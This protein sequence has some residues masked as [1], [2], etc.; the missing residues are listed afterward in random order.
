MLALLFSFILIVISGILLLYTLLYLI[1]GRLLFLSRPIKTTIQQWIAQ[2]YPES[3]L[4]I[5]TPDKTQLHGWLLKKPSIEKSPLV[6]YFGGNSEE[7]SGNAYHFERFDGDWA[8][9]L[10]NY[11]SYGLSKGKPSEKNL[12]ND[13]IAIY[14][15]IIQRSDIDSHCIVAMG[16]S[17]GTGI[18]IHLAAHRPLNGL[19]LVTPYDSIT[20]VIQR[21]MPYIPVYQLLKHP[22]N[23]LAL[24]PEITTPTLALV[25]QQDTLIPPDHA[26]CLEAEWGGEIEIELIKHANHDNISDTEIYWEKIRYFL[27]R[28]FLNR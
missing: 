7:V 16:R 3:E 2:N 19:I 17:L 20:R 28:L 23:S 9:L 26:Y 6:I 12:K 11:R 8:L 22:F 10:I 15:A 21:I 14:D 13:A 18:A 1:Q 4:T 24:A 27:A 5:Q 25:G